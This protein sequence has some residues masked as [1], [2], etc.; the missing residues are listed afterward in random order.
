[1]T[2]RASNIIRAW[3]LNIRWRAD[4]RNGNEHVFT[5]AAELDGKLAI[6]YY[7]TVRGTVSEIKALVTTT[8]RCSIAVFALGP[9]NLSTTQDTDFFTACYTVVVAISTFVRHFASHRLTG[10]GPQLSRRND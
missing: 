9:H 6:A 7:C 5:V 2:A 10:R 8:Y 4:V 1:M 3:S